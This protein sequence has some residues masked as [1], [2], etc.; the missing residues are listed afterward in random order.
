M[1]GKL[2]Q[3][4]HDLQVIRDYTTAGDLWFVLKAE[5]IWFGHFVTH[6][7]VC[8]CSGR[9]SQ[10]GQTGYIYNKWGVKMSSHALKIH[11]FTHSFIHSSDFIS[12]N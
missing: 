8:Q 6:Y 1:A 7:V 11:S 4:I 3:Y 12:I 9:G 2:S 10:N 5:Y